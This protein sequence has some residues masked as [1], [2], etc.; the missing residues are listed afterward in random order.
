MA[1]FEGRGS[2][3]SWLYR[4]G[5]N[6]C[7]DQIARRRKRVLLHGPPA[8]GADALGGEPLHDEIQIE[9]YP[10]EQLGD[11]NGHASP[12]ASYEQ[13]E[14]VELAFIAALQHLP[15]R[16]RAA[17]ILHDVFGL[18]A[19]EVAGILDASLAAVNS[20]LQ[21]AR[22]TLERRNPER[23]RQVNGRA[24]RDDRLADIER[25]IDA[26]AQGDLDSIVA[27]LTEDVRLATPPGSDGEGR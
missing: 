6:T 1:R 23:G 12:A 7:L 21:R 26:L 17:L 19:R 14:A 18:T 20:L 4:I 9:P 5:T 24:V 22:S 25:F 15:P 2:V 3:R 16:Q 10:D 13:R 8:D 27:L 11:E